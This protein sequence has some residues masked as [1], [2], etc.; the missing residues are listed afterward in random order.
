MLLSMHLGFS[1]GSLIQG[2]VIDEATNTPIAG[3]TVSTGP[4]NQTVTNASGEFQLTVDD[5]YQSITITAIGYAP[6]TIFLGGKTTVDVSLLLKTSSSS[7]KNVLS[8]ADLGTQP[9][10]DLEQ[11]AQG[12]ASGVFIQNS[13][14]KL[15]QGA[16][17]RVRGGSSLT[18]SNEPLYVVNGVP[19]TSGNQS[20]IDPSTIESMEILKDASATALYGSR[21]ANGVVLITTKKGQSGKI[22]ANIEYQ[23]GVSQVPKK[24]DMMSSDEYNVMF[25][26]YVLRALLKNPFLI[27]SASISKTNLE[28][29]I[30]RDN[31]KQWFTELSEDRETAIANK[32]STVSYVFPNNDRM[33]ISV[34]NPMFRNKY[35]TDWHDKAFRTGLSHRGNINVSGGSGN[36][37]IFA[38]VN[39]LDQEGILIGNDYERFGSRLN[40]NSQWSPKISSN[41]SFG[42]NRTINNKVQEDA[43]DG[44]PVQMLLLPPSDDSNPDNNY[45]LYVRSNEY[46]PE[47]EIYGSLNRE[48]T[49]QINANASVSAQLTDQITLDI[50]GG[51]DYLDLMDEQRQGPA[52]QEGTPT[53]FSQLSTA[54]VFNYLVNASMAYTKP[55]GDNSLSI[56]AGTSYQNSNTIYE[57]KSARINSISDLESLTSDDPSLLNQPVPGSAFAFLSFYGSVDYQISDKYTFQ[58]SARA[59]GS[60]RFSEDNRFGIFPAIGAGWTLSNESFLKGDGIINFLQLDASYGLLGN[61][62]EDDFLYRTNYYQVIYGDNTGIRFSNYANPDLKWESTNQLDLTLGFGLFNNRISGSIGYYSK[63][64]SDL[65][66][67]VSVSQ[68]SGFGSVIKNNG[69][70][71]NSGIEFDLTT[72]NIDNRG[73]Q[74]ITS[75]NISSNKNEIKDI[76][77]QPLISGNNAFI[78]G[79]AAGVFYMPK[80]LGVDRI[81]GLALYDDG[82]GTPTDDYNVALNQGRQIVG[83][84]NP[85]FYGGLN[86]TFN[87]KNFSLNFMFQFVEGVDIYWETGEV[88]ANSGYANYNQTSDQLDRWYSP[89]DEAK[90]PALDPTVET[91]NPSSRWIV[92]G[93]YIRLKTLNL[94]YNIP[95]NFGTLQVYIGGQNLLTF[96][97]YPGYDP[98]V[99]YTDPS[100]GSFAANINKGIDYF[101]APQPRI[102]TTGIKIG[103]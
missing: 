98:D 56:L 38:N 43:N 87:Y 34:N 48:I 11:S 27:D 99:S 53:G 24:L 5:N 54:D 15:G 89:G 62:P 14:G 16:K 71:Q 77:G 22:K 20:D 41:L 52:T 78:E 86:N 9:V 64:T 59:D 23:F 61:T 17:V 80:Y 4:N 75:F 70:L 2:K 85:K 19:L 79:E 18:G 69:S 35:N 10:T 94:T 36:Q 47:T 63:N 68:T 90:Y 30:S 33:T 3:A 44:N 73:F 55:L 51:M 1:Q 103:F 32:E 29:F 72:V 25:F 76:G 100:G 12:R 67:P 7:S 13:G 28:S 82:T 31:L 42:Y 91:P 74:W 6:Q 97:D 83:N 21:A 39:Y 60:S 37:T 84:P 45:I 49:N 88:I 65:L 92:D 102:Y 46:N 26:E 50:D 101:T 95:V 8:S 57:Y 81:S 58:A 93:S 96:S 40:L 66:F